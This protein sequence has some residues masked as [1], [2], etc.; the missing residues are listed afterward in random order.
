MAEKDNRELRSEKSNKGRPN[1]FQKAGAFIARTGKRLKSFFINLK[2]ELKRVVWPDRKR[3][4][5]ST[6]TVLAICL[7]I[8]VILFLVDTLVG[9]ILNGVGFYSG[10]G[11]TPTTTTTASTTTAAS[12]TSESTAV[13]VETT[14]AETSAAG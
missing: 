7:I 11:S 8:A 5:Q 4:I 14:V 10:N 1:F 13:T 9:G 6:G 12:E 2:A 3:L